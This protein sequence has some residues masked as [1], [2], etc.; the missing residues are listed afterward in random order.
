MDDGRSSEASCCVFLDRDQS[1]VLRNFLD[2]LV[3]EVFLG[4]R[5][6]LARVLELVGK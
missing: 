2:D 4:K 1:V 3:F 5:G 6:W